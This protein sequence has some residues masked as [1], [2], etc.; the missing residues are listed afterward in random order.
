MSV[1]WN[2]AALGGLASGAAGWLLAAAVFFAGPSRTQ[3]RRLALVL[4]LE[5]ATGWWGGA[6]TLLAEDAP[7]AF[8]AQATAEVAFGLMMFAY[9]SFLATLAT[10]LVRALRRRSAQVVLAMGALAFAVFFLARTRLFLADVGPSEY[11]SFFPVNGPLF[12][13]F[14]VVPSLVVF[15]FGL[16]ASV[17]MWRLAPP[18]TPARRQGATYAF[19]FAV[20]DVAWSVFL[21]D[22][23]VLRVGIVGPL[24]FNAL[25]LVF[26]AALAYG[27]LRTQLFDLDLRLKRLLR[28]GTLV[29]V[30]LGAFFIAVAI[31]EQYL[32][33]YGVLVGGVAA[34]LLLF[35]LRPIE[36]AADRFADK[37]MPRVRDDEEYRTVRKRDVYRAAVASALQDGAF[38]E[39]ERDVLATLAQELGLGPAEM[40]AIERDAR[41]DAPA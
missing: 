24:T 11:S 36:R 38:T 9:P 3:N 10:P 21:L 6:L 35:A 26:Q 17:S 22:A 23:F 18:G 12:V 1:A 31:A 34:G 2:V 16:L 19:A 28:R 5:G 25:L 15:A 37:A 7:T 4:F 13:P 30:F 14:L 8:G 27:I 20:R 29:G 40:R 33:R 41:A 32:Q 39:K